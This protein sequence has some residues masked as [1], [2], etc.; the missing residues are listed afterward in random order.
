LENLSCIFAAVQ[1][2]VPAQTSAIITNGAQ[3]QQHLP[4]QIQLVS[5]E[6]AAHRSSKGLAGRMFGFDD[7]M[8]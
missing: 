2:K 8:Q 3:Q 6:Q 5:I 7:A 1:F 4:Q